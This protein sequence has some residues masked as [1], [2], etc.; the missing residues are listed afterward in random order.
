MNDFEESLLSTALK[1]LTGLDPDLLEIIQLS[2]RV[3]LTA[4]TLATVIGIPAGALLAM[5]RFPGRPFIVV[6][7]NTFMGLPPVVVGLVVYLWLSRSG[8]LGMLGLLY[9]P[10]AM[11]IAQC[12]LITPI[13]MALSRQIVE[14]I[15]E[16]YDE[17]LRSLG[18]NWHQRVRTLLWETRVSLLTAVLAGFGR[19]NAE[20]G[21]VMIVGGNINHLTRVMTTTIAYETSRGNLTLAL[22]LGLVLILIAMLLT[23]LLHQ[24]RKVSLEPGL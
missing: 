22:A 13:I 3:T 8:P 9:T 6:L 21:A 20:V 2:L 15:F 23:L 4:V 24:M 10:T 7:I 17:Q 11:I 14:D 1:L 16:Q 18:A 19:A 12:L 5:F